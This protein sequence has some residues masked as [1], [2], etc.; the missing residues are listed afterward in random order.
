MK[1]GLFRSS[2]DLDKTLTERTILPFDLT[3]TFALSGFPPAFFF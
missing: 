2:K 3:T 1:N